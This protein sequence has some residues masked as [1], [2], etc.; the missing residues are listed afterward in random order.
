MSSE[1]EM[2][3]FILENNKKIIYKI[4]NFYC[5]ETE[6]RKDLAQ[7]IIIQL[8]KSFHKYND[9]YRLS[10]WIYSIGLNVAISFYRNK[11]KADNIFPASQNII[12]LIDD[13]SQREDVENSIQQLHSFIN[14]LDQLNKALMI[15]YLDSKS[16]K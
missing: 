12:E 5:K 11:K 6:D 8:W 10:T 1:E 2:F 7:E 9:Q 16:Y 13:T 4:C 15:L 3:I 14:Q